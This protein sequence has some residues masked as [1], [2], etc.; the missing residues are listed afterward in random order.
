MCG[1]ASVIT[2]QALLERRFDS[3]FA[4]AGLLKENINTSVGEEI[5]VITMQDPKQIQLFTWGFTPHWA[6]KQTYLINARA[7]GGRNEE[8]DR[9]YKGTMGIFNKPMF[10]HAIR[11]QRCIILVDAIIEGPKQQKLN[12]PYV[13]YPNRDRGPFAI[14]GIYDT[15]RHPLSG[16]LHHTV[17]MITTAGNRITSAIGH[18]RAPLILKKSDEKKWLDPSLDVKE[19]S[20]MMKPFNDNGFNAYP[21]SSSIK[22]P[23]AN[24]LELLK[25][26]GDKLVK[27]YDRGFYDRYKY[28]SDL[29]STIKEERLV[30]GDQF[31]LF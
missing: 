15:W 5:P 11:S 24:G 23:S 7:E 10:R 25:P 21:I 14:A 20:S 17:A 27:D 13:I 29:P 30:E 9:N 12:K 19:I 1:R 26:I 16:E 6:H 28:M 31:V 4:K 8:N 18:H 22:Q 3:A 2:P